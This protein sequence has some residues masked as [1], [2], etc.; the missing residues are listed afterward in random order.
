[1]PLIVDNT[2]YADILSKSKDSGYDFT[3][4]LGKGL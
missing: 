3:K 2:Y 1:L 4:A